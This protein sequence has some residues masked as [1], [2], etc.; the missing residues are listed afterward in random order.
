MMIIMVTIIKLVLR[1]IRKTISMNP[2]NRL[3]NG[4]LFHIVTF[5]RD[6]NS[7]HSL[8]K[9]LILHF[10][11]FYKEF[12]HRFFHRRLLLKE[13]LHIFV[14]FFKINIHILKTMQIF[15]H[16]CIIFPFLQFLLFHNFCNM[17]RFRAIY[18]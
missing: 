7:E 11:V 2:N 13:N 9:I 4:M 12:S 5:V 10:L 6:V 14:F 1:N 16:N 15:M 17:I 8:K 3:E 18:I